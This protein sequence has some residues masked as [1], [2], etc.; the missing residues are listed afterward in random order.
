MRTYLTFSQSIFPLTFHSDIFRATL[1][2]EQFISKL[3]AKG[4]DSDIDVR[5]AASVALLA[6]V[7]YG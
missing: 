3:I 7:E 6:V 5:T 2:R 1:H 4:S